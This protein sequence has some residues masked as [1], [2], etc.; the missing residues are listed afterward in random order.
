MQ[1]LRFVKCAAPSNDDATIKQLERS[2]AW[3]VACRLGWSKST[4]LLSIDRRRILL[5]CESAG[6][7]RYVSDVERAMPLSGIVF[8][9]SG[10]VTIGGGGVGG[11]DVEGDS[12]LDLVLNENFCFGMFLLFSAAIA[13][14]SCFSCY[15]QLPL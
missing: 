2:F 1:F 14:E 12:V 7:E 5:G 4:T 6:M 15:Y 3:S 9:G 10:L 13:S 11:V 8:V